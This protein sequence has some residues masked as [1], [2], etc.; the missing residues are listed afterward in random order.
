M[1]SYTVK[2]GDTLSAIAKANNTT[3]QQLVKDNNISNPNLIYAGQKINLPGSNKKDTKSNKP[4]TKT[5]NSVTTVT[6]ETPKATNKETKNPTFE[7]ADQ[8]YVDMALEEYKPSDEEI[9]YKN[10]RDDYAKKYEDKI[11]EGPQFSDTVTQ[12]FEWLQS[13]QEYFKNGKTSWDDKIN[14]QIS[15]IENRDPFEYDVDKDQLFQQALSSAMRSGQSAMQDTIGQASALTG[16]YGSTYATSAGNQ[17]YNAFIEDAYNNLPEYYQLAL[18]AYKAEAEEMYNLL[19]I[20]TQMGETEWNRNVDAHNTVFDF[21]DSQR[22]FEYGLYNDEVTNLYN[23][24]DMYDSFYQQKNEE[25]RDLWKQ[26]VDNA[27]NVIGTQIDI[28]QYNKDFDYKVDRDKVADEQW[29]TSHD[30]DVRQFN[31]S[32]GDTNN[33][34]VLSADEIA[35]RDKWKQKDYDLQAGNQT[36]SNNEYKLS[37]G[38]TNMD[39]VL[40]DEEKIASGNYVKNKDGKIV[41]INYSDWIDPDKIEVDPVTGEVT[42][43]DGNTISGTG[44]NKPT[45]SG[46]RSTEGDNFEITIGDKSYTVENQ[47]K[48]ADATTKEAL[49]KQTPNGNIIVYNNTA[50]LKNGEDFYEIGNTDGFM[51]WGWG[52]GSGATDLILA[53]TKK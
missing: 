38:D 30:E 11:N 13:Q 39:G 28:Y 46:F 53:L 36:R 21:A 7:G 45:V 49:K 41:P 23:A 29:Q 35:E 9:G 3:V 16:G 27:W 37:T 32:I 33:D 22:N 24:M 15:A 34:G 48:V 42:S 52:A 12:A 19:G 43:I 20:Y 31:Y 26:S 44:A 25:G 50:Y 4:S 1:A 47:G 51:N 5:N 14:S 17:A 6:P 2:K 10:N 40:S 8:K 18:D